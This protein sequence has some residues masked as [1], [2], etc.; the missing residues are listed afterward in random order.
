MSALVEDIGQA[1]EFLNA[2]HDFAADQERRAR[3]AGAED[4]AEQYE[5]CQINCE[6]AE[7]ALRGS[8]LVDMT[9]R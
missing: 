2:V 3:E 6:D 5:E 9:I 4:E 1:E 8:L 7:N